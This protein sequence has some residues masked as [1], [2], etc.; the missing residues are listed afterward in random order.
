MTIVRKIIYGMLKSAKQL[1]ANFGIEL[2]EPIITNPAQ[3]VP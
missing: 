2:S 1:Y 3:M